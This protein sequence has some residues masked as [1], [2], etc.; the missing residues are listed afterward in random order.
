MERC[1]PLLLPYGLI[2]VLVQN[3]PRPVRRGSAARKPVEGKCV[4]FWVRRRGIVSDVRLIPSEIKGI[5]GLADPAYLSR[6]L[7]LRLHVI[8]P[9]CVLGG[10]GVV[11]G[12]E[13][14]SAD[15]SR[16]ETYEYKAAAE[17]PCHRGA[18]KQACQRACPLCSTAPDP[19]P[20]ARFKHRSAA[21]VRAEVGRLAA[22]VLGVTRRGTHQERL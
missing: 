10:V 7:F 6:F 11:S 22:A 16:P 3:S 18:G 20:R 15:S 5:A 2:T 21:P 8:A 12:S 9:Y 14:F 17:R 13:S 1:G 19:R 4:N